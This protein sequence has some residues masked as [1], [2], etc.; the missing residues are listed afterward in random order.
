[1]NIKINTEDKIITLI[2]AVN[3]NDLYLF[4]NQC[5]FT[6]SEWTITSALLKKTPPK[7][8]PTTTILEYC[9]NLIEE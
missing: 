4:M 6:Y 2:D 7:T 9:D 3:F 1:M 5:N 8:L